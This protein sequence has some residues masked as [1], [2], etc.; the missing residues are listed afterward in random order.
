MPNPGKSVYVIQHTDGE[1]LGLM[2][3]HLEGRGIAFNYMRPHTADGGFPSS[4][5]STDGLIL[6]GGGPWGSAGTRN[7]PTLEFEL[8]LTRDCLERK[9]PVIG[10]GVGAQILAIAAGGSSESTALIFEV[11][12]AHRTNDNALNG[13]L[14]ESYPLAIYM[15]DSLVLPESATIL[16]IDDKDRPAAFQIG[17]NALGFTGHPGVKSAMIE[18]LIME[19]EESPDDIAGGLETLRT[20]QRDL[21]EALKGIMTGIVQITGLMDQQ[22]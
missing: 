15:R 13:F 5:D 21:D 22:K 8:L 4:L 6:L 20:K 10:I 16:S 7:L 12:E 14:P 17:D 18:D 19:F 11:C 1:F 2:E 9:L 3:D